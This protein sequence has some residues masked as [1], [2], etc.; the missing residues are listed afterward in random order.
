MP[1][2]WEVCEGYVIASGAVPT[3]TGGTRHWFLVGQS[4]HGKNRMSLH[5]FDDALADM[6]RAFRRPIKLRASYSESQ[7]GAKIE[8]V[9]EL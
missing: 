8:S 9:T 5:T 4:M 3:S 2:T 6:I 7:W 1:M